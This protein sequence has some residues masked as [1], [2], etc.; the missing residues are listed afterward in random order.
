MWLYQKESKREGEGERK[1]KR[2]EKEEKDKE[3]ESSPLYVVLYCT[4]R[5]CK[6]HRAEPRIPEPSFIK[7]LVIGQLTVTV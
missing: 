4:S 7:L 3:K 6:Q 5:K 1:R 2:R